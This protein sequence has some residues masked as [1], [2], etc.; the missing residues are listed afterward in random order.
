MPA[1]DLEMTEASAVVAVETPPEKYASFL[2]DVKQNLVLLERAVAAIEPRFT[3]RVLRNT[4]PLRR[5]IVADLFASVLGE[6]LPESDYRTALLS[7]V[8]CDTPFVPATTSPA[9][10]SEP[11]PEIEV[12]LGYLT[13]LLVHDRSDWDAGLKLSTLL[14]EKVQKANRRTLDL[15][16]ARVYY[17]YARFYELL[18]RSA[19]T[20]VILLA[21]H[22][23]ATLRHDD[24]TQATIVNLL[25]RSYLAENL[26]DQAD[27]L[28]SKTT[29]PETA[30]NNQFAR[31]MYCLGRIKAIQLEYTASHQYLLQAIRKAPQNNTTAAGFQQ[32]VNKLAIIVQLLMGEIPERSV[33][34]QVTLRKSLVPYLHLTQA[35]K[36]GDLAK[37]QEVLATY[38]D[39]FRA[40]KTHSLILRLRHNVIKTGIR[41]ISIS[42]SRISLRDIC[43][44]LQL[45]SEED[46]EYIVAK[47]IRDGVIDAQI[48]HEAGY[49][50]SRESAEV[51]ASQEPMD[52]YHSRIE[53]C[54]NLYDNSVKALRF[55]KGERGGEGEGMARELREEE[56]RLAKEI[57]DGELDE[58]DDMG[59][60]F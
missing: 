4:A 44:K 37:F 9:V 15:L 39:T 32:A 56:R 59:G 3:V 20:R 48:D 24:E 40:D 52:A 1:V 36:I 54:L 22:R 10:T 41:M 14:V 51:Y 19:D 5:R 33:F 57:V 16:A 18:G 46:A 7:Y 45:D 55:P 8:K 34:W 38:V 29:F 31:Y 23:T 26:Y 50:K 30:A 12:Y 2:A 35:V 11:L 13:I 49:M 42:Y 60:D 27:K 58:D 17:F 6:L 21:A 47:A 53:F 43:L 28:V 25:L